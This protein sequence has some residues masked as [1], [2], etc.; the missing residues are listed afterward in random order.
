ML[1]QQNIVS[2]SNPLNI[3]PREQFEANFKRKMEQVKSSY[4]SPY[5][6]ATKAKKKKKKVKKEL[7]P[8][9]PCFKGNFK[10]LTISNYEDVFEKQNKYISTQMSSIATPQFSN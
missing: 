10:K 8:P 2:T 1:Q 9:K 7:S 3:S 6:T 4:K 5:R